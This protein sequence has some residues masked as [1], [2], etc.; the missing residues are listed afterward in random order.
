MWISFEEHRL[1]LSIPIHRQSLFILLLLLLP[2]PPLPLPQPPPPLPLPQPLTPPPPPPLVVID[3]NHDEN[4]DNNKVGINTSMS[5]F[6]FLLFLFV[7]SSWYCKFC[8]CPTVWPMLSIHWYLL[9]SWF[10]TKIQLTLCRSGADRF[11]SS[12]HDPR[13]WT[14]PIKC[15]RYAISCEVT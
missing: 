3:Y 12:P 11:Q 5:F 14:Q 6:L 13:H 4:C 10:W 1:H 15:Y 2:P 7:I 9:V 8:S